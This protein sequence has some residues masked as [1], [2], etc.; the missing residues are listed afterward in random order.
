MPAGSY[1]FYSN[2]IENDFVRPNL[3]ILVECGVPKSA[4]NKIS[5]YI[6]EELSED[7]VIDVVRDKSLHQL[8]DINRYEKEKLEENF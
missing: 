7:N 6:S 5:A 8:K 3:S 2:Q 1:T 4:I